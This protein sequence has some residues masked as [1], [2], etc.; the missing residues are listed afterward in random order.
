[1]R[2][3]KGRKTKP[4]QAFLKDNYA[5]VREEVFEEDLEVEGELPAELDGIYLR[6]GPNPFYEPLHG[7]PL[8]C[9][10]HP[11]H[12]DHRYATSPDQLWV[13]AGLSTFMTVVCNCMLVLLCHSGTF[14]TTIQPTCYPLARPI[15]LLLSLLPG[16]HWFD[17][18]G[19]L[20]ACLIK[21]GKASYC[22]RYVETSKLKQE[23]KAGRW[24][25]CSALA[26]PNW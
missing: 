18:D 21:D 6:N 1:V 11:D 14:Y 24:A 19:M 2:I 8:A 20:H 7:A 23:Q 9:S 3:A 25:S 13:Q 22:N 16:Y 12:S 17:G 15:D 4:G 10:D 5:P 26:V